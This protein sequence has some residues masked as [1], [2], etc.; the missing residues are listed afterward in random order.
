MNPRSRADTFASSAGTTLPFRK[1]MLME[2][3]SRLEPEPQCIPG[4]AEESRHRH[5]LERDHRVFAEQF[6]LERDAQC[7]DALPL[8][9]RREQR[10]LRE[11]LGLQ[12]L[13]LALRHGDEQIVLEAGL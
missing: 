7:A 10:P 2:L 3:L 5:G 1:T 6:A 8:R 12:L 9:H 13:R 11:Q 4:T